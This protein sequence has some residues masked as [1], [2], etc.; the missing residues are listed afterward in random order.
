MKNRIITDISNY[1]F[2]S[3]EPEKVEAIFLNSLNMLPD[4]ITKDMPSGLF[5]PV[6]LV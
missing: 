2:V 5:P 6:E 4:F 1:I 3:D